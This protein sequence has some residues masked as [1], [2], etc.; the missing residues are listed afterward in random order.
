MKK[1]LEKKTV[2]ECSGCGRAYDYSYDAEDCERR[3]VFNKIDSKKEFTITDNHLKLLK[4]MVVEWYNCEY[5]APCIDPKRPYGNSDVEDDIK[6]ITGITGEKRAIIHREMILV[7]Q[8]ICAVG[9]IEVGDYIK[10]EEYS[11]N[12][13]K[14]SDYTKVSK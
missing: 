13:W 2:Y 12:S 7:L 6:R 1:R 14:K 8:I 4:E 5:G 3:H 10:T 9:K 11:Y